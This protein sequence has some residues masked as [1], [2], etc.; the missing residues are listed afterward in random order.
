MVRYEHPGLDLLRSKVITPDN[1]IDIVNLKELIN[2]TDYVKALKDGLVT[3]QFFANMG[4]SFS[5]VTAKY[6]LSKVA[7]NALRENIFSYEEFFETTDRSELE[8]LHN[9]IQ[10]VL[11]PQGIDLPQKQAMYFKRFTQSKIQTNL[12]L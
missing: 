6:L 9:N 3:I 12:L 7:L 2:D 11:I 5:S 10:A 4:R 8:L 1:V